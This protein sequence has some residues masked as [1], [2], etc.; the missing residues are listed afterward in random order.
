MVM[1][2]DLLRIILAFFLPPMAV[3]AGGS[4]SQCLWLNLIFWLFSFGGPA[5]ALAIMWPVAVIHAFTSS[6]LANKSAALVNRRLRRN[7]SIS[8]TPIR[9]SS[10]RSTGGSSPQLVEPQPQRPKQPTSPNPNQDQ[11]FMTSVSPSLKVHSLWGYSGPSRAPKEPQG[12]LMGSGAT[13]MATDKEL[14]KEA[15]QELWNTVKKLRPGSKSP[16]SWCSRRC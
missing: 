3:A 4:S 16:L 11:G 7:R 8:S 15:D 6:S 5:A 14:I 1:L 12:R 10:V 9:Q 13:G 2:A